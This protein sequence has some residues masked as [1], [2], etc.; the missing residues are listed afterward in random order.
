MQSAAP[1]ADPTR[2]RLLDEARGLFAE[3]GFYGVSLAQI[4]G[5]LGITK[6]GLLHYFGTKERLYGE[7]L[8]GIASE[9][10]ALR[11][12]IAET[13]SPADRLTAYL[14]ALAGGTPAETERARLLV[15]ELLDNRQRAETARSWR[16][17]P[18]LDE[19]MAMLRTLPGWETASNAT[20]LAALVPLIGAVSYEAISAP[21][22]Q[23]IYGRKTAA[24]MRRVFQSRYEA[25][26]KATLADTP[27]PGRARAARE[28]SR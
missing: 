23:G 4:A 20:C 26:V 11:A 25:M 14:L 16:L 27:K 15:R 28:P 13:G 3:R 17:K 7:V 6:Q 18:F 8:E 9:Y 12:S 5:A 10:E 19:L 21:T 2:Q 1:A 22:F 24:D